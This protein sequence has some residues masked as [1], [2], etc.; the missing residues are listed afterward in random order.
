MSVKKRLDSYKGKLDSKQITDGINAAR[1]NALRLVE[2]AQALFNTGRYP[3]AASLAI[4]SIEESGKEPILRRLATAIG[5]DEFS[6]LWKEYRSHTSKNVMW[7]LPQLVGEGARQL[8]DFRDLFKL[9]AEHPYL[10][11]Q[12]KQISF[13]TD[14]L[15]KAHWSE[16]SAV[17]DKELAESL[18]Q[19]ARLFVKNRDMEVK[20]IELWIKHMGKGEEDN[21]ISQKEALMRWYAEMIELGLTP[22]ESKFE[23]FVKWL[24]I[25]LS[26]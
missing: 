19:I 25:S 26:K 14:C 17:I 4:L 23:D 2:D 22:K 3:T 5:D 1:Q 24:G 10:L 9:D 15:G 6:S 18:M 11:E 21:F 12:V 20:E 7:L 13:Y 16:P 8:D